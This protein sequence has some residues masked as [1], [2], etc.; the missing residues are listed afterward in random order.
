MDAIR[1]APPPAGEDL[2]PESYDELRASEAELRAIF[3][4]MDDVILVMDGDGRYLKIVPTKPDLLYRPSDDLLGRTMHEIM[5]KEAADFFLGYVRR[6][7]ETRMPESL[8]YSMP[9]GDRTVWF[10]GS[11]SP[12]DDGRVVFMA[13]DI[14]AR[15]QAED[16]LRESIRQ[17]EAI[18]AQAAALA[19][20]ST[21]II[22]IT[23]EIVVV[24]LIGLFDDRR[25]DQAM[26]ALLSG[27]TTRG[28]RTAIID[29]TGV[30][31]VD[32]RVAEGLL[33]A[34][35]AGQLLGAEIVLTGIQ[36]GA[37]QT[38]VALGIDLGRIVTRGTLQDGIAFALEIGPGG[39]CRGGGEGSDF[40]GDGAGVITKPA[41]GGEGARSA[42]RGDG[43]EGGDVTGPAA[44]GE[45]NAC[46][47]DTGGVGVG[48]SALAGPEAERRE[49]GGI[50]LSLECEGGAAVAVELV[51]NKDVIIGGA[52][53][54]VRG[55]AV[56][57]ELVLALHFVEGG[58]EHP[59]FIVEDA[60]AGDGAGGGEFDGH[61]RDA[62][63]GG[64][65]CVGGDEAI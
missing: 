14:T 65:V 3:G 46:S 39:D 26:S 61:G 20:L 11:L 12:M 54:G 31:T 13:R 10:A 15:K 27:I 32:S 6:A 28:A 5:P 1:S 9:I 55:A 62:I 34:A 33:R 2:T 22:P 16:A 25:L 8:E 37:A 17:E 63:D 30:S 29:I 49:P 43:S 60:L 56:L 58:G 23:N 52:D 48:G 50:D 41:R 64:R 53:M 24:P 59:G 42:P 40:D 51:I 4:A 21:P 36:P 47:A 38:L 57:G 45:L 35:R 18:R 7:I 44:G 19:E